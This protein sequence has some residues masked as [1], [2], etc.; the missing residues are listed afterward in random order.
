MV[1]VAELSPPPPPA[2]TTAPAAVDTA[3]PSTDAP[4]AA[5]PAAAP[6]PSAVEPS[7]SDLAIA[8]TSSPAIANG[9]EKMETDGAPNPPITEPAPSP[10]TAA[11]AASAQATLEA[12]RAAL[13]G[14]A[15]SKGGEEE[16]E[17][18]EF[19]DEPVFWGA[20][21]PEGVLLDEAAPDAMTEREDPVPTPLVGEEKDE[22]MRNGTAVEETGKKAEDA[23]TTPAASPDAEMAD[24]KVDNAPPAVEAAAPVVKNRFQPSA[25]FLAGAVAPAVPIVSIAEPSPSPTVSKFTPVPTSKFIPAVPKPPQPA[26]SASKFIPA[27]APK[28][29]HAP[30]PGPPPPPA[31]LLSDPTTMP[32]LPRHPARDRPVLVVATGDANSSE[33][34]PNGFLGCVRRALDRGWDVEVVAFTHGLSSHWSGEQQKRVT[35]EGRERGELRVINLGLFAEELVA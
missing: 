6:L 3:A 33:Y 16:D 11:D 27:A 5:D 18:D 32:V 35:P 10:A 2:P 22:E 28:L 34:N 23:K 20:A 29:S 19:D 25:S 12:A 7:A 15:S 14:P 9:D 26:S 17:F 13:L 8:H 21:K 4:L 24:G 30:A 1:K 31:P